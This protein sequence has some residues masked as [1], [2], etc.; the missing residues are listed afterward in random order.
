[1]ANVIADPGALRQGD[2]RE[3]NLE[4]LLRLVQRATAALSRA[5][6]ATRSGLTRATVST[7]VDELIRA[8]LL[9]EVA[10]APRSGAGRPSMGLALSGQAAA[11]L[12]LEVNVDYLAACV[13]DLSGRVRHH[14][15]VYADQRPRSADDALAQLDDL[16][17]DAAAAADAAGLTIAGATLAVPGLVHAGRV[18][19]APNLGWHDVV[20]PE[21]L[22]GFPI[23][24]DNEA[25][26][27]AIGEM[28]ANPQAPA[29]FVY[30]SGE[31]GIG[32]GI[33]VD[34]QVMRG[35]RGFAGEIGHVAVHP[36][37]PLC[38]CGARGCLE[39]FAGQDAIR[40]EA[41]RSLP[42]DARAADFAALAESGNLPMVTALDRAGTALGIAIAGVVNLLDIDTVVLGGFFA[43]LQVWLQPAVDREIQARVLAARWTPVTVVPSTLGSDAAVRGSAYAAVQ[44]VVGDPAGWIATRAAAA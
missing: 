31:I 40:T 18:P 7:L 6:L 44:A 21:C 29:S 10:P 11:G 1:M 32:A 14:A 23:T 13:V 33:V 22:G 20:I 17:H 28:A 35:G 24:V 12:G 43:P 27:A 2:L 39:Q 19:L 42:A 26:L 5:E 8:E 41:G 25:N 37:G 9:S 30:I 34:G 38:R 4:L 15:V 16:A 36:D 3:H